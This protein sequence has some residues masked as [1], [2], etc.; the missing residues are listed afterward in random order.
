MRPRT[1]LDAYS[2]NLPR[3]APHTKSGSSDPDPV[4]VAR[5]GSQHEKYYYLHSPRLR[6]SKKRA[7]ATS[8]AWLGTEQQAIVLSSHAL[9]A[10]AVPGDQQSSSTTAEDNHL[11]NITDAMFLARVVCSAVEISS[12]SRMLFRQE[13]GRPSAE[14]GVRSSNLRHSKVSKHSSRTARGLPD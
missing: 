14:E 2:N 7:N 11:T 3:T 13:N 8:P 6:A 10:P 5:M 4:G 1:R 12:L 9:D